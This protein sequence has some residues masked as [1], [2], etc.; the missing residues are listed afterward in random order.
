MC[1]ILRN[2]G[3]NWKYWIFVRSLGVNVVSNDRSLISPLEIDVLVQSTRLA[4]EYNGLYWHS[5]ARILDKDYHEKRD[6]LR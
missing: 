5:S 6:W 3:V 4:I 1:V 2:Q